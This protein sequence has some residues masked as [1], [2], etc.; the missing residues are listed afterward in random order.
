MDYDAIIVG[1]G[2][3]GLT[4]AYYLA[5][6]GHKVRLLERREIVGGA[7]ITETFHP[8]FRNSVASYSVSLLS[9]KVIQDLDLAR[10]GLKIVLRPL[11]YFAPTQDGRYLI[12]DR[13]PARSAREIA[14]WSPR[15]AERFA[16]FQ[17]RLDRLVDFLRG[18]LLKT[19]PNAG[20]GIRDLLDAAL[21]G[22]ALRKLGL[23][24]QS[25]L[26][27]L[28]GKSPADILEQWFETDILKGLMGFDTIIGNYASPYAPGSGY[29][30]LHHAFGEV[31]GVKGAWGH[32]LGGMGSI[33][34]AMA[35]AAREA[36]AEISVN[37]PAREIIVEQGRT[38]AAVLENGERLT[39]RAIVANV[40]PRLLYGTLIDERHLTPRFKQRIDGLRFGSGT[41]RMNVALSELPDFT[42]LPGSAPAEHHGASIVIAPSLGYLETAY[43]DARL[44]GWAQRPAIEMHLPS[45]LDASL[46]PP[47]QHVASLFCQHFAPKLPD[48]SSW[49]DHRE[50]AADAV[51]DTITS[52]AP[53]FKASILAR[54]ILSPLDLER[55]LALTG[56]D[57]FH[58]A[59]SLDQL[60]SARPAL[61]YGNY[62]G[63]LK[64]LY[65][66]GSGTHP[67]GGVTG[68]P[69]HNAAREILRD[70]KRL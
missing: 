3:N 55:K 45:T 68:I 12:L 18:L 11:T 17:A 63:P 1:G 49:D 33:T 8:G 30:L 43:T 70:L 40:T 58:G 24:A 16:V 59:L 27:E 54:T 36:G 28:F 20:G 2:H 15:D 7:A 29:I 61:G 21:A 39:A 19:P 6:A 13:D 31:N 48:G 5:K 60:F 34:Q 10:H 46:A 65:M 56:G 62:R 47:G 38:T 57:I 37:A 14:R 50:A 64:G 23:D 25:D 44:H 51:I 9:P 52:F 66:C 32:A 41:L 35:S 67:G 22:N 69:G 4:C 53:N 42:A 26:L